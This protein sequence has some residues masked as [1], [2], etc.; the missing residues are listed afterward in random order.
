MESTFERYCI[1]GSSTGYN[2][3]VLLHGSPVA[4]E[5]PRVWTLLTKSQSL[6]LLPWLEDKDRRSAVMDFGARWDRPSPGASIVQLRVVLLGDVAFKALAALTHEANA[7][8]KVI[9]YREALR[10]DSGLDWQT[11]G[12]LRYV[13]HHL[14]R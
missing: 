7:C 6:A 14:D 13:F 5:E 3:E 8:L 10:K 1:C 11:D 9:E 2:R 4:H 12:L